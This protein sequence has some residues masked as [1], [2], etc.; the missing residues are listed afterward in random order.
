LSCGLLRGFMKPSHETRLWIACWLFGTAVGV[1]GSQ[2]PD[3]RPISAPLQDHPGNIFLANETVTVRLPSTG[4][5]NWQMYDYDGQLVAQAKPEGEWLSFGTVPVGYY[6][7]GPKTNDVTVRRVALGVLERLHA[8]TPQDS[9]IGL[10]V[11]MSWFY[12]EAKMPAVANLCALAGINWVR[13][14]LNWAQIESEKGQFAP[15]ERYDTSARVQAAAG[16]NVLQVNHLSPAWANPESKRFPMDLRDAYD[17]YRE[18]ARRWR[19][20]IAAFEPWNEADIE[21]FGGHTGS[22]MASLQKASW[23]GLKA[24]NPGIIACQ[25]VYALNN[26]QILADFHGN[27]AWPYFDTFNLHHYVPFDAYPAV[28]AD[29]RAV[30]AGKP[31]WVTECSLPVQWSG[32]E[33]LKEPSDPDLRIQAERVAK[34]YAASIQEG[35]AAVFY[36]ILPHFV[37]GQTQFGVLHSDLTPRPAFVALAAVGRLL[38]AAKPLGRLQSA[39]PQVRGYLFQAK[40]DGQAREV[41]VAWTTNSTANLVLPISP[42]AVFDHLGRQLDGSGEPL[43]LRSAPVFAILPS[44]SAAKMPLSPPPEPTAALTGG[45]SPIVLQAL[46]PKPR[47]LLEQSAYRLA[48]GKVETV[49][50]YLYNFSNHPVRGTFRVLVPPA[51]RIQFPCEASLQPGERQELGLALDCARQLAGGP[52]QTIRIEGDFGADGHPV[53]S[54]RLEVE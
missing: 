25:N 29:F 47:V 20:Q 10:D 3:P 31:L 42:E 35:A 17:A 33:K 30:S 6:E 27:A 11:A 7:I 37:E 41:L 32:D 14:R 26:R 4:S 18:L 50:V 36:F 51:A 38:A 46:W 43:Y 1:A 48:G 44:G 12:P 34:V 28:Y 45:V 19:G 9:P 21:M 54:L 16:L 23:L 52:I 22:E 40:P 53:L 49:P 39:A 15:P 8:P 24:G 2:G 5:T 13:D